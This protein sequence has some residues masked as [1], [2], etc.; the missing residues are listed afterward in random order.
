M[1]YLFTESEALFIKQRFKF[2][3]LL[4]LNVN[5][6]IKKGTDKTLCDKGVIYLYNDK[7]ELRTEYRALFSRWEK[8]RYSIVRPELNDTD[9]LQCLLTDGRVA[10]F[11]VRKKD[12][13]TIDLV[14]F[15]EEKFDKMIM[16]FAELSDVDT[17][18]SMFNLSMSLDEYESFISVKARADFDRWNTITG[19]DAS[20]LEK[21]VKNINTK[22][23]A[24]MLLVEDHVADCGYMAK[25]V[26]ATDGIYGVKHVTHGNVQKMVLFYG[27]AQFVTDSI[28]NF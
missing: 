14:D 23:E 17:T 27:N 22:G 12:A 8:M 1:R 20:M 15:S 26:N 4:G 13:I 6:R 7:E 2:G 18:N 24:Q 16:S 19:I 11:F 9:H 28:Y 5:Q 25:I 3:Q 10:M 21:Y